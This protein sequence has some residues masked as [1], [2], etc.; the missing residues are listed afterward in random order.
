LS[1]ATGIAVCFL[2][3]CLSSLTTLHFVDTGQD[4]P[5]VVYK[6]YGEMP[7]YQYIN[8]TGTIDRT[9]Y[10]FKFVEELDGRTVGL[11]YFHRGLI[12]IETGRQVDEII[13]TCRHEIL[14]F[15]FPTYD[16]DDQSRAEDSIYRLEDKVEFPICQEVVGQALKRQGL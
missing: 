8:F 5:K 14:H 2:V 7:G 6:Q 10:D 13:E 11:A 3:A 15:Y 4:E 16:H 9:P 12:K 1:K